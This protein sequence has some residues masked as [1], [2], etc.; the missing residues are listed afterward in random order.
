L[1]EIWSAWLVVLAH[2]GSSAGQRGFS[3]ISKNLDGEGR[4]RFPKKRGRYY[5]QESRLESTRSAG[6]PSLPLHDPD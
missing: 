5:G 1:G 4:K 3:T 2:G 6:T